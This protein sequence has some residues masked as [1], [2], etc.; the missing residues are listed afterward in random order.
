MLQA[1]AGV[2]APDDDQ[3]D[4]FKQRRPDT[5][6]RMP[7]LRQQQTDARQRES[8]RKQRLSI[9]DVP[10]NEARQQLASAAEAIKRPSGTTVTGPDKRAV[11][12]IRKAAV[13]A[14]RSLNVQDAA[15]ALQE[16]DDTDDDQKRQM[17][18]KEVI[19]A[20]THAADEG[21]DELPAR[22]IFQHVEDVVASIALE[23]KA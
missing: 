1:G 18:H 21:K 15:A 19:T 2:N 23:S 14:E 5:Q 10:A 11:E 4:E 16:A 3:D 17:L 7:I 12:K 22:T 6:V 9:I 8:D 20:L 13:I